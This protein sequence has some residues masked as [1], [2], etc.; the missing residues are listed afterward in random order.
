MSLDGSRLPGG[1]VTESR[2]KN[3]VVNSDA[4]IGIVSRAAMSSPYVMFE[5]GARWGTGKYLLPL[6]THDVSAEILGG[7][8]LA[9]YHAVRSNNR[10]E[11]LDAI[12][13]ICDA[14]GETRA[15]APDE[16][17]LDRFLRYPHGEALTQVTI[18]QSWKTLAYLPL[19]V[20]G[21]RRFFEDEGLSVNLI[22]GPGDDLAWQKVMAEVADFGVGDPVVM[23]RENAR[24]V[25]APKGRAIASILS[26]AALWGVSRKAMPPLSKAS[27]LSGKTVACFKEPS[28]SFMI[29][30]HM[31]ASAKGETKIVGMDPQSEVLYLD[32]KEIDFVLT[33]EPTVTAAELSGAHRVFSGP[34]FFG[35]FL[36]TGMYATETTIRERSSVVQRVVNAIDRSLVFIANNPLEAMRVAVDEF[37]DGDELTI[38]LATLRLIAENVFAEKAVVSEKGWHQC[39]RV[40]F[41]EQETSFPFRDWVD[42]SF[43]LSALRDR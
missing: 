7:G 33:T 42:N 5:L 28:T 8:P 12:S 30:K 25:A 16:R 23:L 37:R 3:E 29:I 32:R 36:I 4:F 13:G 34:I 41:G 1:V 22:E 14:A 6:L 24:A 26:K 38:E 9:G 18:C 10:S 20:A 17:L 39:L 19:Y 40:R 15:A 11:V 2:L 31:M 27:Q 35:D 21:R 43:A